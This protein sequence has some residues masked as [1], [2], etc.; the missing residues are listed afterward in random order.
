MPV[1]TDARPVTV[2][3]DVALKS[4][5]KKFVDLPELDEIGSIR[6]VVPKMMRAVKAAAT[7]CVAE[8]FPRF[9]ISGSNLYALT[10]AGLLIQGTLSV[11]LNALPLLT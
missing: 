6:S 3:A 4:A 5:S 2:M 9:F 1:S 11:C 8:S 7:D 10:A